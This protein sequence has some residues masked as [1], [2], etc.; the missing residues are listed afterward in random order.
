MKNWTDD[1]YCLYIN[2]REY[3][4]LWVIL[5]D[6]S[7]SQDENLWQQYIPVFSRLILHWQRLGFIKLHHGS[8]WPAPDGGDE[9]SLGE[10]AGVV[11]DPASWQYEDEP[12]TFCYIT[13]GDRDIEELDESMELH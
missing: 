5:A 6:R 13:V 4:P 11:E 10:S 12:K 7:Q 3:A 8:E 1:E 2:A 9:V